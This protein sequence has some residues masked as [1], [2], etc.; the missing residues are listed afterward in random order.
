MLLPRLHNLL[1]TLAI[2][3]VSLP[4]LLLFAVAAATHRPL[5]AGLQTHAPAA[6]AGRLPVAVPPPLPAPPASVTVASAVQ[7]VTMLL[8]ASAAAAAR[9]QADQVQAAP[10]LV[11]SGRAEPQTVYMVL[12]A[13]AATPSLAGA[14]TAVQLVDLRYRVP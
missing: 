3:G 13:D 14:T 9:V 2:L 6:P 1:R 7:P 11:S 8:V 10:L 12:P 5:R 4:L